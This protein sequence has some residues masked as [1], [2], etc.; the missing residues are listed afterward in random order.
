MWSS[1]GP[2]IILRFCYH[3]EAVC[4]HLVAMWSSCGYVIILRLCDHLVVVWSS[5]GCVIIVIF[6]WL[7]D[8]F[9]AIWS[10]CGCVIFLWLWSFSGFVIILRPCYHLVAVWSSCGCLII[11]WLY[12]HLVAMWKLELTYLPAN[13]RQFRCSAGN[14]AELPSLMAGCY[15]FD[16]FASLCSPCVHVVLYVHQEW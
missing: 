2:V 10:S 16:I 5:W 12:D 14:F 4:S 8:H 15:F 11:L 1:F 6:L 7:C 9:V 3:L 13:G